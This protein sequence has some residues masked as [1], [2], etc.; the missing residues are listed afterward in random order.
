VVTNGAIFVDRI[1][2][3][4]CVAIWC[5]DSVA[6]QILDCAAIWCEV[7]VVLQILWL[8][9]YISFICQLPLLIK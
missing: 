6:F 1:V 9:R 2:C 8:Y 4:F 5:E 3:Q 7:G